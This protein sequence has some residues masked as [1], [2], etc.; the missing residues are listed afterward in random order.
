MQSAQ[1]LVKKQMFIK[2]SMEDI[3]KRYTFDKDKLLGSGGYGSVVVGIKND[4]NERR[5][6][7]II[8]KT[9]VSHASDFENEIEIMKN[10]VRH[11]RKK[12]NFTL[13]YK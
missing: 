7:K 12:L 5:A 13:F 1:P 9:S 6:I 4:S 2:S 3:S 10:L 8:K 11:F